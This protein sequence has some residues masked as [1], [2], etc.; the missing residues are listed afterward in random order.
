M[1]DYPTYNQLRAGT[2]FRP[3][4]SAALNNSAGGELQQS[5]LTAGMP[6][7]FEL[8]HMLTVSEWNTL[9]SHYATNEINNF[10]FVWQLP[11]TSRTV[12]VYYL[13]PPE[14]MPRRP[15]SSDPDLI[16][17]VVYLVKDRYRVSATDFNGATNLQSDTGIIQ[18]SDG[19][20]FTFCCAFKADDITPPLFESLLRAANDTILFRRQTDGRIRVFGRNTSAVNTLDWYSITGANGLVVS[21]WNS[22]LVSAHMGNGT[23][24]MILNGREVGDTPVTFVDDNLDLTRIYGLGS[25]VAGTNGFLNGAL[26]HVAMWDE[27]IDCSTRAVQNAFFDSKG[28]P[29]EWPDGGLRINGV[30]PAIWAPDGDARTNK[31]SGPDFVLDA[32]TLSAAADSPTDTD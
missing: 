10:N 12:S 19:K 31:G 1:S 25:N 22:L 9:N 14:R 18:F 27:Y 30:R 2:E 26:C 24:H 6:G 4:E 28:R 32:G 29:V 20:A 21:G 11:D 5:D 16:H 7:V 3:H 17:A 23:R 15:H 13:G 8:H